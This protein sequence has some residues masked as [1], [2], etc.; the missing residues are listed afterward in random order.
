MSQPAGGGW[1]ALPLEVAADELDAWSPAIG[2]PVAVTGGSGFVGAHLVEALLAAGIRPRLLVRDPGRL[3]DRV[4]AGGEIVRGDLDAPGALAELVSGCGTVV[5]LAGLVR[6]ESAARFDRVNRAGT[7]NLIAAMTARAAAARLVHVS[8]LAAAGPS[9]LTG[10][11]GPEDEP[12]PISAYGRSKL[13]GEGAARS[14][15]GPW[16]ILRPPAVYGPRDTDVLQFFRLAAR[17]V[18]PVPAGERWV[19]V[20]YVADVVRGILAAA[21][22][23]VDGRVLHLGEPEPMTMR[24]LVH[25][26]AA[27]GGVRVRVVGV[28]AGMV[29]LLGFGGDVLQRIGMRRIALTSDKARELVARHWSS[30]TAQSLAALDL[31]G[32]VGLA[33]GAAETWAWYRRHGWVKSRDTMPGT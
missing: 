13:A 20:A 15:P 23:R 18:V 30:Q 27:S 4:R 12:H 22:G 17:G 26:L 19:S 8:S 32:Y 33:A 3:S 14:F 11:V 7:E 28:P 21:G 16:V 25:A 24:S 6:A 1:R 2:Q 5:H 29:R 31:K 10:G 9:P